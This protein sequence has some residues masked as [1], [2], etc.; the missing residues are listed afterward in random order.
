MPQI[1]SHRL[2]DRFA[3]VIVGIG[4]TDFFQVCATS[5]CDESAGISNRKN[6]VKKAKYSLF[7]FFQRLFINLHISPMVTIAAKN[8]TCFYLFLIHLFGKPFFFL[9]ARTILF[10]CI[11][12][13][14]GN[15]YLRL[16]HSIRR[17][18]RD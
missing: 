16:I 18:S 10:T 4:V 8:F 5:I 11:Q 14:L 15:Q 7:H 13:Q 1:R 3:Y 9:L 2:P 12:S 17:N 6:K